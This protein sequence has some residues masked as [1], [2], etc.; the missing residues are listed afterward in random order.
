MEERECVIALNTVVTVGGRRFADLMRRFGSACAIIRAKEEELRQ[1][2]GIGTETAGRIRT[3]RDGKALMRELQKAEKLGVKIAVQDDHSYPA[4]L[5]NMVYPPP[6]IYVLGEVLPSDAFS[7]AIVGSRRPSHYGRRVAG[8]MAKN[9][10]KE[11]LTV[12][13]GMARGIDSA[14]HEGALAG[15][16]RTIA[17]LGSGIDVMYPPENKELAKKIAENG[18][19]VSEFPFGACP[20]PQNF[21]RRNRVI[22]GLALGVVIVQAGETSGAL[23]TA[24]FAL[25]Q[26]REVF[27]VPGE[28]GNPLSRGTHNLIR[29]G[30]RLVEGIGDILEELGIPATREHDPPDNSK[31]V[32]LSSHEKRVLEQLGFSP[33]S[34]DDIVIATGFLPSRV[35]TTLVSLE[36]KG[37][38]TRVSGGYVRT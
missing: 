19:V 37:M 23:I 36:L 22:S 25:E 21:P 34:T 10:V 12:V 16:G 24:D 7:I 8:Q 20:F 3:L 27:A 38:A 18:A 2:K 11:G 35:T 26:G 4:A 28:I 30:A 5:L 31:E 6:A 9:A 13:S 29:Q 1:V 32:R 14:A 33:M 17:V 15:G